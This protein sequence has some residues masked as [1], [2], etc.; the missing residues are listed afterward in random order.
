MEINKDI[1]EEFY[2]IT[3]YDIHKY[4]STV[5]DFMETY[6]PSV[7]AYYSGEVKK[8]NSTAFKKLSEVRDQTDVLLSVVESNADAFTNFKWW[9]LIETIEKSDT[10]IAIIENSSKWLRSSITK[11]NFSPFT[12]IDVTLKQGQTL[13]GLNR[14]TI[15]VDDWNNEWINTAIRN[16]LSE[17]DY[18]TRGGNVLQVTLTRSGSIFIESVVDNIQ[19]KR[20]IYG[21][22]LNKKIQF[23]SNDLKPLEPFD[24][25]VQSV[26]ILSSLKQLDNPYF[27]D[28]GLEP[29]F[30]GTN[31]NLL[32]FASIFRQLSENFARND[33]ISSFSVIN[34]KR[35]QDAL[36]L[37][38]EVSSRI[39]DLE[40]FT[41]SLSN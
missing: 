32:N 34:I 36:Y 11:D 6:Y 5:S 23:E 4:L 38:Y 16:R 27:P 19:D 40:E 21:I 15:R 24:T 25:F 29:T 26:K 13:E 31:I 37:N 3:N 22:D 9:V 1:L 18:D 10:E 35:E 17:T 7:I 2:S 30:I 33:T 12:E 41:I 39:G 20:G 14:D 28:A 8:P